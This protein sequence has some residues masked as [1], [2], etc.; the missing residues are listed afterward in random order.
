MKNDTK[1]IRNKSDKELKDLLITKREEMSKLNLDNRQ[2][3]LKNTR[4]VFNTRKEV[5]RLLTVIRERKLAADEAL[6]NEPAKAT[7]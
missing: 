5:A 2:N 7:K 1:E 4:I 3:K 6:L